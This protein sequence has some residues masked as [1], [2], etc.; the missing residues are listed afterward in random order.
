MIN[1]CNIRSKVSEGYGRP[2][3]AVSFCNFTS[4]VTCIYHTRYIYSNIIFLFSQKDQ[5][6]HNLTTSADLNPDFHLF[7]NT[8]IWVVVQDSIPDLSEIGTLRWLVELFSHHAVYQALFYIQLSTLDS[9][10][11]K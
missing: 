9:V 8:L 6:L 3:K 7:P 10:I 5:I 11:H 4:Y 2:H 1:T